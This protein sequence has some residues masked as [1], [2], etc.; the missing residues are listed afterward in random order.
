MLLGKI[1]GVTLQIFSLHYFI[2]KELKNVSTSKQQL[3]PILKKN[4]FLY[5]NKIKETDTMDLV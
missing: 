4:F 3:N 1:W 5:S 2:P